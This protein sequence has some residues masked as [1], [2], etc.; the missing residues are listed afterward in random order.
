MEIKF[1]KTA[2]RGYEVRVRR[3][4]GVVL[5]LRSFDRPARLPHDLVHFVVESELSLESGLWGLLAAG[6]LPPNLS[7]VSGRVGPRA[8]E[9]SRSL[10]KEAGRLQHDTEA[11][12]LVAF[13]RRVAEEGI[14]GDWPKVCARLGGVWH[15]RRSQR[16]PLGHEEVRRACRR[17]REAGR[18]WEG[19]AAGESMTVEWPARHKGGA[20]RARNGRASR[21][22]ACAPTSAR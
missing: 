7:V 4:D 6:A 3:D 10:L 8:A 11:E 20:G 12:V 19:L 18:K 9:R 16:G 1:I 14:E 22:E 15:P 5:D 13:V 21:P 2:G 17:L